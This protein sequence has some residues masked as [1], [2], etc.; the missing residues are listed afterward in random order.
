MS[1]IE[2]EHMF[3]RTDSRQR[4]SADTKRIIEQISRDTT[5]F[6]A[7]VEALRPLRDV[8]PE[9]EASVLALQRQVLALQRQ[10]I[11][12]QDKALIAQEKHIETLRLL[13][14]AEREAWEAAQ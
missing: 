8:R 4:V 2:Q 9:V 5:G 12:A 13:H 14:A 7:I 11:D 1:E 6:V 10:V 3:Q